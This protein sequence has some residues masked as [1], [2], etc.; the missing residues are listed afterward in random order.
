MP[1]RHFDVYVADWGTYRSWLKYMYITLL[2][3]EKRELNYLVLLNSLREL[4]LLALPYSTENLDCF[5]LYW[6]HP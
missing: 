6:S 4:S 1:T 5:P 2:C 3:M